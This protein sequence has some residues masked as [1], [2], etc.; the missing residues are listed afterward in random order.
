MNL[1]IKEVCREKGTTITGLADKLNMKQV[2][3][4]RI[5]NGNPTIGTLQ[6]I[7]D[8]LNVPFISL[9]D[10]NCPKCGMKIGVNPD[11]ANPTPGISLLDY[12]LQFAEE[13]KLAGMS[14]KKYTVLHGYLKR[15][16]EDIPLCEVDKEYFDGFKRYL[17]TTT[18]QYGKGI[19]EATRKY[20]RR[21]LMTVLNSTVDKKMKK[22]I[23]T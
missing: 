8:A 17:E 1:R 14:Y 22:W 4:S 10:A 13:K 21:D 16:R 5:I 3:L 20:Y 18:G 19:N 23:Y 15:Y 11:T 2:S 9:F 7:A 6:K 12:V